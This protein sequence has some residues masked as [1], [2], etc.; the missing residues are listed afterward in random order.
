M[1]NYIVQRKATLCQFTAST[2]FFQKAAKPVQE[3]KRGGAMTFLKQKG[4]CRA[5]NYHA[6]LAWGSAQTR[7]HNPFCTWDGAKIT[8]SALHPFGLLDR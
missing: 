1:K 4:L 2:A 8:P 7:R 6:N 5:Y 3:A